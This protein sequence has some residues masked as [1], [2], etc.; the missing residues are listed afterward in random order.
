MIEIG[1]RVAQIDWWARIQQQQQN[2]KQKSK[3][4]NTTSPSTQHRV[5]IYYELRFES[6]QFFFSLF[7][8]IGF[9]NH[10]HDA[11]QFVCAVN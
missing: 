10:K 3:M 5:R 9:I 7:H 1:C 11:T 8:S 2:K 4:R 6:S